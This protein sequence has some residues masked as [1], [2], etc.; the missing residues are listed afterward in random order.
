MKLIVGL[1][2]PG[3]K[4]EKTRHNLGF[5]VLEKFLK[6]F[7]PVNKTAWQEKNKFK[8]EISEIEWQ[9]RKGE[10]QK[11]ILVK[12]TTYMN[13]SG[14]AISLFSKFYKIPSSDIFIVHDELDLPI[15]SLKIRLGGA[16]AGHNGVNSII[17]SLGT[18]KFWRL[19]LGIGEEKAVEKMAKHNVKNTEDFVLSGFS[20]KEQGKVKHLIKQGSLALQEIL[21]NGTDSA[22]NKFNTR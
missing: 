7:E 19:R 11:V 10:L 1:G 18:D 16:S 21:E 4:Y 12:P 15:G 22:M 6:D 20:S 14:M 17:E 2:N 8:S 3:A 5:M 9:P 13:N